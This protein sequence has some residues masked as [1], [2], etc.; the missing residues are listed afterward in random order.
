[1]AEIPLLVA[2]LVR[3]HISMVVIEDKTISKPGKKTNSLS[4]ASNSQNQ[5][6]P[7]DFVGIIRAFKAAAVGKKIMITARIESFTTRTIRRDEAE[8]RLSIQTA[9]RDALDRAHLYRAAGADAIMIHSKCTRPD[10]VVSFLTR[11]RS[12]DPTTP[13]VV[14]PTTYDQTTESVLYQAGANVIIYANHLMR[15]KIGA[16]SQLTDV[17]LARHPDLFSYNPD[18][19]ACVKTKNFGCLLRNLIM[20]DSDDEVRQYRALAEEHAIRNMRAVVRCLLE[21]RT[22]GAAEKLIISVKEL[23]EINS[24]QICP[25]DKVIDWG[26]KNEDREDRL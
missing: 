15:A 8:E 17:W 20:G 2:E 25:I 26:C 13:I 5:A 1:M 24:H 18:L 16:V 4:D 10:E 12:K 22:S 14:V 3:T 19:V 6:K 21:C 23:L 9:L 11:Y 7:E